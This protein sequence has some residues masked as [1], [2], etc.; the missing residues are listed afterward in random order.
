MAG[1]LASGVDEEDALDLAATGKVLRRTG[2]FLLPYRRR[3][4]LAAALLVAWTMALLAGP[5]LV[6]WAID[7]GIRVGDGSVVNQAVAGYVVAAVIAYVTHRF[8]IHELSRVG[9][10]F[11]RDLRNRVFGHVMNQPMSYFDR[12][13]A[14]VIVSRM[15]ADIDSMAELV[16]YG[17]VMFISASLLLGLTLAALL[18]LSWQLTLVVLVVLPI[19]IPASIKFKRDSN[20][21]YLQVRDEIA[22]TLSGLQEGFAGVRVVQAFAREDVEA[23]RFAET[24]DRLYRAHMRSMRITTWY[25]PIVDF[26]GVAT[27]A[28][29]IA[30]G[31]LM[32]RE[33]QLSLGTVAAFVLLLANLFEPV[34]N[35]S[36]LF[37]MVQ[38]GAASLAKL[39]RIL[40][41]PIA[42]DERATAEPLPDRGDLTVERVS[43]RYQLAGDDDDAAGGD[44][45]GTGDDG[46]TASEGPMVLSS[47]D[48]T[49]AD[50]ERLALVGPTGAGKST[51]AKLMARLYDPVEGS[52]RFGGVD[53]RDATVASLRQRIVVVPQEGFLFA[54]TVADNIRVAAPGASDADVTAALRRIGAWDRIAALPQGID[55]VVRE[56]GSRLSA[57]ERQ[58]VSLARAAVV[59]PA[60]LV[61]DEATSSLDPGTEVL[62]EEA[63]EA[64]MGGR[65]V[66]VIAHRLSTAE[67]SDRVGVVDGGRLVELGSHAELVAAGGQYASLFDAWQRG[68]TASGR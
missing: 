63:M 39:Y 40:D 8:G 3:G 7:S 5:M 15:T 26:C 1:W 23:A 56:R 34:Q 24:N 14:G 42:I 4:L 37:N 13:K 57:G 66:I 36:L 2:R 47:V 61:L 41:T 38:S 53:L 6:R 17:L 68:L 22:T 45:T 28:L 20:D 43:F 55:T 19:L 62:V 46:P 35:L 30:V 16:Q 31:G 50:G 54:G 33:G 52:V 51:L 27:T 10:S 49:V 64:L 21:A 58:L 29:A 12:T 32:V 18:A 25:V 48:V 60:V 11:L 59:D 44:G 67:R 9:E 65:T